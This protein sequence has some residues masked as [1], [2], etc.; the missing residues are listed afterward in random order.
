VQE[1]KTC[2]EREKAKGKGGEHKEEGKKEI[3]GQTCYGQK[4]HVALRTR[5]C[6]V[7]YGEWVLE[8]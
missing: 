5:V 6:S 7:Q 4:C 8:D 1:G 2:E 3:E